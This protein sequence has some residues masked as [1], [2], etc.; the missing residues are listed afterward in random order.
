MA[1]PK[2]KNRISN[3]SASQKPNRLAINNKLAEKIN[4]QTRYLIRLQG[5]F[6][7]FIRYIPC[8]RQMVI[9]LHNRLNKY[10]KIP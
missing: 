5:I 10:P 4:G 9:W 8:N 3:M 6:C 7:F 1:I 2:D